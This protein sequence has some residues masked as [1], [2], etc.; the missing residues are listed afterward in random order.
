MD[1]ELIQ[2]SI[3]LSRLNFARLKKLAYHLF[4]PVLEVL[5]GIMT[6]LRQQPS[7]LTLVGGLIPFSSEKAEVLL[8]EALVASPSDGACFVI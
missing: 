4:H 5:F 1:L 2:A 8:P 7:I 3:P 6:K